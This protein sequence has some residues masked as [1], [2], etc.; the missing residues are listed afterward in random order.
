MDLSTCKHS[1]RFTTEICRAAYLFFPSLCSN[2]DAYWYKLGLWTL[3]LLGSIGGLLNVADLFLVVVVA[4]FDDSVLVGDFV[5][6]DFKGRDRFLVVDEELEEEDVFAS[7]WQP[8]HCQGVPFWNIPNLI[9]A[10]S[11]AKLQFVT[12]QKYESTQKID[13][14]PFL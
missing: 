2:G 14:M 1:C 10:M 9:F 11:I 13:L 7:F 6:L 5:S 3:L 8:L 4:P 12:D